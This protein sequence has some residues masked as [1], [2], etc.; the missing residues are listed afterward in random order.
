MVRLAFAVAVFILVSAALTLRPRPAP[1]DLTLRTILPLLPPG[2]FVQS[3]ARLEMDGRSPTELAVLAGV[4]LYPRAE[5]MA[6]MAY[7][8]RQAGRRGPRVAYAEPLPGSLPLAVEAGRLLGDRDAAVFAMA[9]DDGGSVYQIVGLRRGRVAVVHEGRTAGRPMLVDPLVVE[10]GAARRALRWD[11]RV[12]AEAAPPPVPPALPV[13][14]W[15]YGVRDGNVVA[16]SSALRLRPRQGVRLE[17]SGGGPTPVTV[18]DPRLDVL[19]DD[20]YRARWPGTYLIK[21]FVIGAADASGFS[22][23]LQVLPPD[24]P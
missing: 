10:D 2:T 21:I 22:L 9:L 24:L 18:P 4:P 19:E 1:A 20:V 17:R 15:R 11:G 6:Y 13:L 7:V 8:F 14:T 5:R 12:F 3:T 23:A 16:G